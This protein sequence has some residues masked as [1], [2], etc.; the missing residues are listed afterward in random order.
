MSMESG[1][2]E[3]GTKVYKGA[4]LSRRYTEDLTRIEPRISERTR[5]LSR[6]LFSPS[7]ASF[8]CLPSNI[9]HREEKLLILASRS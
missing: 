8:S 9:I 2:L 3:S 5:S 1:V 4:R 7:F 6:I